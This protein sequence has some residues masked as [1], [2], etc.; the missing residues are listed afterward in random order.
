MKL[1]RFAEIT[2]DPEIAPT[3]S[4]WDIGI[5]EVAVT[6]QPY[7]R[8]GGYK[9]GERVQ[10][11]LVRAATHITLP[12]VNS[13]GLIT[14]PA[15]PRRKCET[16]IEH[17]ANMVAV[18]NRTRR[19]IA[20]TALAAAISADT[21]EEQKQLDAVRG[22]VHRNHL[23][24]VSAGPINH[25]MALFDALTGR[26]DGVALMAEALA[27]NTASGKMRDF[28]RLFEC[29]FQRQFSVLGKKLSQT[30]HP[31]FGYLREEIEEW[32]SKR[33]P[34][35]HADSK[36]AK[37]ILF[38]TDVHNIIH[39]VEQAAIDVLF[40]KKGLERMVIGSSGALVAAKLDP[41]QRFGRSRSTRSLDY[42]RNGCARSIQCV[43]T[44]FHHSHAGTWLAAMWLFTQRCLSPFQCSAL[45]IASPRC[46]RFAALS[47]SLKKLT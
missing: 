41:Q 21:P 33:D 18:F 5:D 25:S 23:R 12:E 42:A 17:A 38:D 28:V 10:L 4:H 3:W 1:L 37:E 27:H 45:H 39:R 47:I 31:R 13:E 11:H 15:G 24:L 29:A 35:T 22:M 14:I 19:R 43:S 26:M 8:G 36:R 9:E 7:L 2:Y 6:F 32:I 44:G 20:S 40:N 34:L 16:A 30:L 46:S